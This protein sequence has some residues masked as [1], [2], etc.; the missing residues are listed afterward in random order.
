MS[1]Y[2]LLLERTLIVMSSVKNQ[3]DEKGIF[4]SE[5]Y[6]QHALVD[7]QKRN[8]MQHEID[9]CF[10]CVEKIYKTATRR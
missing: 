2:E 7:R 4:R 10:L 8:S 5:L 3:T 6:L 1:V 9:F